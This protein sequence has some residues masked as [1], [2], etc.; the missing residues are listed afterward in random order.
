MDVQWY[1]GHMAKARR[2]LK[3]SLR[4]ADFVVEV[5]DARAPGSTLNPDLEDLFSDKHVFYVLNKADL[6]DPAITRQW[7]DVL[8]KNGHSCCT[9]SAVSDSGESLRK[10]LVDDAGAIVERF[11][12]KGMHKTLRAI[13]AGVPNVGKSAVLNRLIGTKKMEEG[14][15]PGVT[16]SLQ[17]ARIN[18]YLEVLDSPGM[19]WPKFEDEKTGA[20]LALIGCVPQ[21]VLNQEE[22]AYYLLDL[23]KSSEPQFI[24]DRYGVDPESGDAYALL[25]DVCRKRGFLRRGGELDIE[26]G[27]S[28][29]LGEFRNGKLGALSL[30]IPS[31]SAAQV[32]AKCLDSV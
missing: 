20:T 18:P 21:D 3:E 29:L 9:Y 15:K 13:V 28:T 7:M 25:E 31:E 22:L 6:A 12:A 24:A 30:E 8:R 27:A 11:E 5:L 23:L 26:R 32:A 4:R 17:W 16:R 2:Q 19:L 10:R 1:P 14:N